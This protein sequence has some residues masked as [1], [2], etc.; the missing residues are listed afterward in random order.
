M[1]LC[2]HS[3]PFLGTDSV[4]YL[5]VLV[6]TYARIDAC[7]I[8]AS[9]VSWLPTSGEWAERLDYSGAIFFEWSDMI[10]QNVAIH[11]SLFLYIYISLYWYICVTLTPFLPSNHRSWSVDSHPPHPYTNKHKNLIRIYFSLYICLSF[12]WINTCVSIFFLLTTLLLNPLHNFF[13]L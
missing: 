11:L 3:L 13:S 12:K 2:T 9:R 1:L 7:Y 10:M 8:G 6:R 5:W 4:W